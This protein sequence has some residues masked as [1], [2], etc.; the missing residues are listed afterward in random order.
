MI[1]WLTGLPCSGKTTIADALSEWMF[2]NYINYIW[3]DGDTFRKTYCKD[4]GFSPE[5]RQ[6]NI[7]R[8]TERA[9]KCE[10]EQIVICSFVSPYIEMRE[11]IKLKSE[12]FIEVFVNADL[13]VC[14]DRDIKGMYKKA[15]KKEIK[16]FTGYS[17][18]YEK[19]I[20]PD[21]QCN[22]DYE[23]VNESLN[24]IINYLKTN[25]LL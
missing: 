7:R 12:C 8:V 17:A 25:E 3:L 16:E 15:I 24:K 4:L 18:P 14:M 11:N 1:L 6:E 21:I 13:E 23:S 5:D 10:K 19:P 22:T 20:T 2:D 9:I